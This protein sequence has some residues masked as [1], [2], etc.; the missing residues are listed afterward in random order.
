MPCAAA[1]AQASCAAGK[2]GAAAC[3][4]GWGD[5][6][7][8]AANGCEANLRVDPAN[9][10]A[11]KMACALPNA[12]QAC[13]DGC[14]IAACQ[15]GF[16]DCDVNEANGCET[17]VLTDPSN[18]GGCGKGCANLPNASASCVDGSC[19]LGACTAG[20]ADCNGVANDGCEADLAYD[21]NNCGQCGMVCPMN[22]PACDQGTCGTVVIRNYTDMFAMGPITGSQCTDWESWRA[23]LVGA[24]T[25]IV[26][27]G[28]N[29][30]TGISCTGA[31]ANQICQALHNS[32]TI[33]VACNN[34]MWS[35]DG[36]CIAS[37]IEVSIDGVCS[38][39]STY[40]ARPCINKCNQTTGDWGGIMG[41]TCSAP[42]QTMTVIC[43]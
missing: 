39:A 21:A 20:F 10:S 33:T 8:N 9:C 19:V 7:G 27:K 35:V 34:H 43:Q 36:C 40:A 25:M 37:D 17:P 41:A 11:C 42:A 3:D 31:A 2:C 18:C 29:D 23:S 15:F 28:S 6:D 38:C 30:Q 26:L 32:Q 22:A 1:H 16:D 24:F 12:V 14:Y 13:A 5:C 4:P